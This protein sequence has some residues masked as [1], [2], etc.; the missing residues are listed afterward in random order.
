ME[1]ITLTE[2]LAGLAKRGYVEDFGIRSASTHSEEPLSPTEFYID[3]M[4]RVDHLT[5]PD[6]QVIVYAISSKDGK[7]KGYVINNFGPG[8]NSETAE[9]VSKLPERK[10]AA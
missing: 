8:A 5:D 3:E 6:E 7:R 4:C 10:K 1:M 9:L 2:T